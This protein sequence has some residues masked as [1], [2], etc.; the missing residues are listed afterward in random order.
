MQTSVPVADLT[1]I[2]MPPRRPTPAAKR[3]L[4]SYQGD[5]KVRLIIGLVFASTGFFVGPLLCVGAI[6]DIILDSSSLPGQGT[7]LEARRA[8]R[9]QL[10]GQH[11]Y[12]IRYTYAQGGHPHTGRAYILDEALARTISPGDTIPLDVDVDDATVSRPHGGSCAVFG[13]IGLLTLLWPL[14]GFAGLFG[15]YRANRREI[16]AYTHGQ[17][18]MATLI[19]AGEDKKVTMGDKHPF[20]VKWGFDVQGSRYEGSFSTFETAEFQHFVGAG[21]VPVL[22]LPSNP[23]INTLFVG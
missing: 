22:Y 2:P 21:L 15:V 6:D 17:A 9:T 20:V 1:M 23:R 16:R 3:L 13:K 5:Q 18:V 10:M 11:P 8:P 14:M 7:V 4:F 12:T 19:S